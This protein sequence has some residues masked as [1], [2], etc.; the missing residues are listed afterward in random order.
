[1]RI[2]KPAPT[3]K[4]Y[5]F[6]CSGCGALLEVEQSELTAVSDRN[7]TAYTFRCIGCKRVN[8]VHSDLVR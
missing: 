2:L 3:P 8:Y 5:E 6:E 1:M 7:S 4:K